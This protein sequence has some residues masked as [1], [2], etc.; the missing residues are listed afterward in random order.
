MLTLLVDPI[1][2]I[3]PLPYFYDNLAYEKHILLEVSIDEE[4]MYIKYHLSSL[5]A[6]RKVHGIKK[7]KGTHSVFNYRPL[8]FHKCGE[9]DKEGR[10]SH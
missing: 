5:T 6:G 2:S 8:K 10:V 4:Y 1:D 7:R 9:I 3:V